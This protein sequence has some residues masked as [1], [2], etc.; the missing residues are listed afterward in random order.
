[1]A[2]WLSPHPACFVRRRN[3]GLAATVAPRLAGRSRL[4]LAILKLVAY[5]LYVRFGYVAQSYLLYVQMAWIRLEN[6]Y[7]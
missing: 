2:I 7:R 5:Q 4:H 1:M 6:L 3:V